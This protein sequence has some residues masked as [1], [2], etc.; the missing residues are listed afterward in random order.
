MTR[1]QSTILTVAA[2]VAGVAALAFGFIP[3]IKAF[4]TFDN[5]FAAHFLGE[6]IFETVVEIFIFLIYCIPAF[7]ILLGVRRIAVKFFPKLG[8]RK[9]FSKQIIAVALIAVC[10]IFHFSMSYRLAP[11]KME[12]DNASHGE[13]SMYSTGEYVDGKG[14]S[15]LDMGGRIDSIID[16]RNRY[17]AQ[18]QYLPGLIFNGKWWT[19]T[20]GNTIA[21]VYIYTGLPKREYDAIATKFAFGDRARYEAWLNPPPPAPAS[22]PV[23]THEALPPIPPG[24]IPSPDSERPQVK[25]EPPAQKTHKRHS[26]RRRSRPH[27]HRRGQRHVALFFSRL[28]LGAIQ[29]KQK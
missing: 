16:A 15:A 23:A 2:I 13:G 3:A 10:G 25:K 6:G 17:L 1:S 27:H 24:F 19:T 4:M 18:H 14:V 5:W 7:L 29:K 28:M 8:D 9:W 22:T 20:S 26:G 21:M 11:L 12:F